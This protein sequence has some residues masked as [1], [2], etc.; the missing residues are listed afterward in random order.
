ME[1]V[2]VRHAETAEEA[3]GRC[4]GR[5]EV[6]LSDRGRMQCGQLAARLSTAP[7]AAVVSSP[8]RRALDT[9][10]AIAGPHSLAVAELDDLRELDFGELEG[11]AYDEIA[12]SE[13]ALYERWMQAPTTVSFPGGEGYEQMQGR[14]REAVGRL[15]SSYRGR[16]V[17]AV[18]HAGV[19]RAVLGDALGMSDDR[20]FRIAVD[21]ASLTIVE[22]IEN[23]PIV[24]GVNLS[25]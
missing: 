3:R 17:V 4:C 6:D 16:L 12:V 8:R 21:A 19:I 24:R 10:R 7:V 23:A 22:W 18:T 5:L 1:L 25:I 13:P 14:V 2:L 11:R 15:R 9:A 20:I